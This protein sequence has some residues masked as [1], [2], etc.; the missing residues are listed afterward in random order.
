MEFDFKAPEK[1]EEPAYT[2]AELNRR[3]R[4]LLEG[5]F[6]SIWLEAEVGELTHEC[7][8]DPRGSGRIREDNGVQ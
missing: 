7:L 6:D 4:G 3:V 5:D 8:A 1:P 2:V